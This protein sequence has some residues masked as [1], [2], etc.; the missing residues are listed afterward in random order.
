[1]VRGPNLVGRRRRPGTDPVNLRP[2]P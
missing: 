2:S 1:M